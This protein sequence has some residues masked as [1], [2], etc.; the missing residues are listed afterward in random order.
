M[1]LIA[2]DWLFMLPFFFASPVAMELLIKE[3]MNDTAMEIHLLNVQT[4]FN[5]DISRFVSRKSLHDY[6]RD[7][8][9]KALAPIRVLCSPL[10]VRKAVFQRP[11]HWRP[12]CRACYDLAQAGYPA[13]TAWIG[14]FQALPGYVPVPA[15][16]KSWFQRRPRSPAVKSRFRVIED[17]DF[18]LRSR[19]RF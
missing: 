11:P 8:A 13:V 14:R 17:A 7:E 5:R 1:P 10:R 12:S 6:H 2:A 18:P 9:E 16:K 19:N 3:F 15:L 4:P